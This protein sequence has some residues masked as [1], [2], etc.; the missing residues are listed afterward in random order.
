M[1]HI[2]GPILLHTAFLVFQHW[3]LSDGIKFALIFSYYFLVFHNF[4]KNLCRRNLLQ[5]SIGRLITILSIIVVYNSKQPSG[6]LGPR[7][8]IAIMASLHLFNLQLATMHKAQYYDKK[9]C[10]FKLIINNYIINKISHVYIRYQWD[11]GGV[12]TPWTPPP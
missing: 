3:N 9:K 1:T 11:H 7:D 10:F 2:S 6:K 5:I 4:G 12:L 8:N